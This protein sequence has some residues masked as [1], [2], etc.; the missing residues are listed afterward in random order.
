MC[1]QAAPP[2]PALP[3]L[4]PRALT[5]IRFASLA[6]RPHSQ[7]G[8]GLTAT[9]ALFKRACFVGTAQAVG[10]AS[11][12]RHQIDGYLVQGDPAEPAN[13]ARVLRAVLSDAKLRH[14]LAVNGERRV[15]D[16]GLL[17]LLQLAQWARLAARLFGW[18]AGHH[19]EAPELARFVREI[20]IPCPFRPEAVAGAPSPLAAAELEGG[21][22][23]GEA[24]LVGGYGIDGEPSTPASV[25][26]PSP[27]PP[28]GGDI[29]RGTSFRRILNHIALQHKR[30]EN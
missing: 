24:G 21:P 30:R 11:Q 1:S 10:L 22:E 14:F 15:Y 3:T 8:F 9:E 28:D 13:V 29:E 20:G 16:E 23:P 27:E 5:S 12:V 6:R 18:R 17:D 26:T 4:T 7:E 2:P 25:A 19:V